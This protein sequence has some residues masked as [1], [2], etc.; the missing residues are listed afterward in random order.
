MILFTPFFHERCGVI[1]YSK[2]KK[3]LSSISRPDRRTMMRPSNVG[4]AKREASKHQFNVKH[5]ITQI[6]N[7]LCLLLQLLRSSVASIRLFPLRIN[8]GPGQFSFGEE[9]TSKMPQMKILAFL[10]T[11]GLR[12]FQIH[13]RSTIGKIIIFCPS[14]MELIYCQEGRHQEKMQDHYFIFSLACF[15]VK[16]EGK[17]YLSW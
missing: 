2:R 14:P 5:N 11:K 13:L 1:H 6:I 17:F 8:R 12:S 9:R 4:V 16:W 10:G 7:A 15:L 3:L